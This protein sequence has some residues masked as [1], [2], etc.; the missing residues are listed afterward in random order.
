MYSAVESYN[1]QKAHRFTMWLAIVS[2]CMAF[3]GLTSAYIVRKGA[4]NWVDFSMPASFFTS[5]VLILISSATI[6][7]AHV[8]N[9]KG[10]VAMTVLGLLVTMV[11]GLLFCF[12]QLQGWQEL[13]NAGIYLDGNP[14]GSF[15][16]V[17]TGMH[18]VHLAGGVFFLL[19]ALLRSA[20]VFGI[21]KR[22]TTLIEGGKGGL[23]VRTD[24]LSMYW[25]FM[26]I[27]WIYLFVFLFI[28][29]NH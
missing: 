11:L 6:H 28:N 12:Y 26:D 3:A 7:V 15:F 22:K 13:T 19:I 8:S 25:H 23:L 10:H 27:L 20:W 4:G 29:L 9:K 16:Y 18:A 17:I 24:L 21:K 14:S 1:T 5:T 2:I